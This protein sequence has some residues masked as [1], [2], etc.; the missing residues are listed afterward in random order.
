MRLARA[1]R[2]LLALAASGVGAAACSSSPPPKSPGSS[3]H[4]GH[5]ST[6]TGSSAP[7]GSSSTSTTAPALAA[8][9][10]ITAAD[11]SAQGAAGTIVGT[12]IVTDAGTTTC[13]ID[14]YPQLSRFSS[15][16]APV[17]VQV[18]EGITVSLPG[19][20]TEPAATVTLGPGEQAEFAYQYSD[21]PSGTETTCASSATLSVRT[22]GSNLSSPFALAMSPCDGGTVHV[23]PVYAGTAPLG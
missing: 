15:S 6:T 7:A 5:G 13:T 9:T 10:T 21:V 23:S 3:G 22:P 14:G 2:V 20:P 12:I 8:C 17:P 16:G 11:G 1:N 4:S 18:V 19:P